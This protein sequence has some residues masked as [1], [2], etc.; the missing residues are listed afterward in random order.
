MTS[1]CGIQVSD[2]HKAGSYWRFLSD[3]G[4]DDMQQPLG[5]RFKWRRMQVADSRT[6]DRSTGC[7]RRSRRIDTTWLTGQSVAPLIGLM[8]CLLDD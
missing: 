5:R 6:N 8:L 2:L 1:A 7:R 4:L 3:R